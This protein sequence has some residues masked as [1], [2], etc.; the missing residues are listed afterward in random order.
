MGLKKLGLKLGLKRPFSRKVKIL[1]FLSSLVLIVAIALSVKWLI[2]TNNAAEVSQSSRAQT[3]EGGDKPASSDATPALS[4]TQQ[5]ALNL[6]EQ[7]LKLYYDRQFDAA[8]TLF[9]QAL[10]LDPNCYQ[11]LNGKGAAYAFLGRY[12]EGINLIRQAIALKPD[13]EYAHFNLGLANELAGRWTEAIQAY[14][15]ALALDA[16]DVWSYYGIASI[17][18]RQGN[19]DKVIEYLK[20]AIDLQADVR[21]TAR[22]EK[23]FDPVKNDPRFQALL[24]YPAQNPASSA[25]SVPVLYYHSILYE[26]GNE[27]RMPP[28]QFAEQMKYLADHG[29]HVITLDQL[30]NAFYGKSTLPDKPVVITFDDGYRDNFTNA[31]PVMQ[32][33][34]FPGTVFMVSSYI[35]G[36][37][38]LTADQLK[39]LQAA[40]WTI[41]G[42]TE[43]HVNLGAASRSVIATELTHSR[44]TLENLLG[45]SLKYIAYPYGGYNA[46][47]V[48]MVQDDGYLMAFT[49]ER[50]WTSAGLN[51]FLLPRVYCYAN[52]G[53]Q[54]FARRITNPAY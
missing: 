40:G 26:A 39:Q 19:V 16:K 4:A 46:D 2:N 6:Y 30:Y 42:H 36:D 20:P 15:G 38:F 49:T 37:G 41:G 21:D 50:G 35:G 28:E 1:L 33:Y 54:E 18:G 3:E 11:A 14:Q 34:H 22:E 47:A 52:M 7:G 29:Y 13:F 25:A 17:Y 24:A 32:K 51:R 45:R 48:A 23:D 27:L 43:N 53:I 31:F 12:D 8:L 44:R 5:K 10:S 9:N